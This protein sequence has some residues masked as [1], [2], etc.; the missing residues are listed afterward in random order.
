MHKPEPGASAG[1]GERWLPVDD[2]V[3]RKD[4]ALASAHSDHK[5]SQSMLTNSLRVDESPGRLRT[6]KTLAVAALA[7][8]A[9]L[10]PLQQRAEAGDADVCIGAECDTVAFV[11]DAARFTLYEDLVPSS[12]VGRFYYGIP[13]D[14]PLMGDWNCNGE[15]TP[16]MYRRS[17]GLVYLR[18]SNTQGIADRQYIFGNP[19]DIPIIGDFNGDGCD[20]VSIYRPSEAKFYLSYTLGAPIADVSFFFGGLGDTPI[21]GDFD[22]DGVDS[23]GI[24]RPS[25]GLVALTNSHRGGPVNYQFYFGGAGDQIM[26]GDW[27]GDGKD[28]VAIYRPSDGTLHIRNAHETGIADYSLKVG[29]YRRAVPAS[30]VWNV[31]GSSGGS[32]GGSSTVVTVPGI[33]APPSRTP[34]GPIEIYGESN[35][36]IENLHISNPGGTCVVVSGS[37]NV[38]IRNSTIGPCGDQGVYITD[39]ND[40]TVTGN[41]ITDANRG[42]LAHRSDSIVVDG[43]AFVYT[44]RNFVQFDKVNGAGSSISANRGMNQLGESNAEDLI[45]LFESNGTPGSPI[46]IVR[47]YIRGGGPSG[48]GSGIMLGDGGGSYQV[49][50]ENRLVNPGQVGI[51]VAGGYGMEVRSN[52][53]YSATQPWSNV[54]IFTWDFGG[55]GCGSVQVIGNQIDWRASGGYSNGYWDGGGCD[56]TRYDNNWNA[57]LGPGIW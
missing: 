48:S 49:A 54:G 13:G 40:V 42:V 3:I 12:A 44:G 29:R 6:L 8:A 35:V 1:L 55:V 5:G 33:A 2:R 56:V 26:A 22:G 18:E 51:G 52:Y 53:I 14:E 4:V 17:T 23:V 15:Q 32:G 50:R 9:I 47:N 28:T 41:Y 46:Q 19:S 45:S 37:S 36:V 30:G 39:S 43:N 10:V 16:G 11:D 25:T 38:T 21:I 24:F 20:T 31:P 34:S 57:N 27:D 7:A